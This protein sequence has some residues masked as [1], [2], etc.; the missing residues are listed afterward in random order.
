[1]SQWTGGLRVAS[2]LFHI[3]AHDDPILRLDHAGFVF[4]AI[5]EELP[6]QNF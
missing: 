2:Q 1:M 6:T 4:S 3:M 5:Y